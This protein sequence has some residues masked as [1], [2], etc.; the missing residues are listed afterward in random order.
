MIITT[1]GMGADTIDKFTKHKKEDNTEGQWEKL[2][3][4]QKML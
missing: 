1:I 3:N 4:P 2:L